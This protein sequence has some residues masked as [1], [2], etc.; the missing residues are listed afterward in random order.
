MTIREGIT[1]D[2]GLVTSIY[3]RIHDA[4]ERGELS[5]GWVR[6]V[7]PT[8]QTAQEAVARGDLF[9]LESD[10][11]IAGTAIINQEQHE[12]YSSGHWLH[13]AAPSEVMVLHT[14]AVDPR[15][16]GVGFGRRF[17]RF[18]AEY[19]LA[20]GCAYLRMDT[21][22]INARARKFYKRLGFWEA[23]SAQ[24]AFNGIGN[25]TLILLENRAQDLLKTLQGMYLK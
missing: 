11:E 8:L 9:V 25:V 21:N 20:R 18:Y 10:G 13:G 3:S 1:S 17:L 16:S 4:E 12:S 19:A 2:S 5:T 7:Y 6:G 24:T 22:A 23:G 14:L 15:F